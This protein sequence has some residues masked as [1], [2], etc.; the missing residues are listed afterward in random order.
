MSDM[1]PAV[2]DRCRHCRRPRAWL[3]VCACPDLD[4]CCAHALCHLRF[5][6][7][8]GVQ[9]DHG[10][11]PVCRA[12]YVSVFAAIALATAIASVVAGVALGRRL[13]FR[14]RSRRALNSYIDNKL[15]LNNAYDDED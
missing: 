12:P 14:A 13:A 4:F 1:Q 11:C 2:V 3:T 9:R 15:V 5:E 7:A 6:L 10:V 8:G